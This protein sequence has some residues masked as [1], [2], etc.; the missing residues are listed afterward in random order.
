MVI[1]VQ[2]KEQFDRLLAE[3]SGRANGPALVV[4]DFFAT[5]CGPCS[6]IAPVFT[7]LSATHNDAVFLKVDVDKND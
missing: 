7:A 2:D 5:W 3:A 6:A 4:I 1:Q